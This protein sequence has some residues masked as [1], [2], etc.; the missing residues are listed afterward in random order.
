MIICWAFIS[1][2]KLK[3]CQRK[4]SRHSQCFLQTLESLIHFCLLTLCG[5]PDP[6]SPSITGIPR[7]VPYISS[8][9]IV[10]VCKNNKYNCKM[11]PQISFQCSN[12]SPSSPSLLS[13]QLPQE[14]LKTSEHTAALEDHKTFIFLISTLGNN[15]FLVHGLR[16]LEIMTM[17]HLFPPGRCPSIYT[18]RLF[19][20]TKGNQRQKNPFQMS[21]PLGVGIP[22]E[23]Y[24]LLCKFLFSP[25]YT[26]ANVPYT[27]TQAQTE[28][29]LG[30]SFWRRL[31][32][33]AATTSTG[34]RGTGIIGNTCH[35]G[36]TQA[37]QQPQAGARHYKELPAHC[38]KLTAAPA[39]L[40][41]APA[42]GGA[43]Q[44][45]KTATE[46]TAQSFCSPRR[47]QLK[48]D[49]SAKTPRSL[50]RIS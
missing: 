20:K 39:T 48:M 16:I 37:P 42:P 45:C 23:S 15:F 4:T 29:L 2:N 50:C 34:S 7:S 18:S 5:G 10:K 6:A 12:K 26:K 22:V 47:A 17:H 36:V 49:F 44:G 27:H 13:T 43:A 3:V 31:F 9:N 11:R 38:Q 35:G 30:W 33:G 46:T 41:Y 14:Q 8:T 21:L 28:T 40:D 25:R 24:G 19:R 1:I 32:S